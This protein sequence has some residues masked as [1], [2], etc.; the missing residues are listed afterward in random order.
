MEFKLV[1]KTLLAEFEKAKVHDWLVIEEYFS[2]FGLSETAKELR[3][4]Y[5]GS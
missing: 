1:I 4:K 3:R 2:F 5:S